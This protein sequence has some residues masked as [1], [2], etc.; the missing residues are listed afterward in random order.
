MT[1]VKHASKSIKS[2]DFTALDFEPRAYMRDYKREKALML[3]N[4]SQKRI[5]KASFERHL[6]LQEQFGLLILREERKLVGS[7]EHLASAADDIAKGAELSNQAYETVVEGR[8]HEVVFY[9]AVTKLDFD[10]KTMAYLKS[11]LEYSG[12]K[13]HFE[14]LGLKI[15]EFSEPHAFK[16]V[17]RICPVLVSYIT[18]R[19]FHELP[20]ELQELGYFY[21]PSP[22]RVWPVCSGL[23]CAR[24][25]VGV[26]WFYVNGF[27]E[28]ASRGVR[29]KNL[30][31]NLFNP[32][33]S[34][35]VL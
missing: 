16:E 29:Q 30:K 14:I 13:R 5:V 27:Y 4:E 23:Q 7:L 28:A 10:F 18:G 32:L 22:G 3:F 35:K 26:D 1:K 21:L 25:D 17:N 34:Q 33:R 19:D 8:R 31:P 12:R 6:S 15:G 11:G 24:F 9:E 2:I 20:E